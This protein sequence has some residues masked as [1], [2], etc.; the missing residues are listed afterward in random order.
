M[1][2]FYAKND[3]PMAENT[4]PIFWSKIWGKKFEVREIFEIFIIF[5]K[6]SVGNWKFD[7]YMAYFDYIY[8]YRLLQRG[9]VV[10]GWVGGVIERITSHFKHSLINKKK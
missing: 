1:G 4:N 7:V 8:I 9:N 3:V 2:D 10:R 6:N 5:W